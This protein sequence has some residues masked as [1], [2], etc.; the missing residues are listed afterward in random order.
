MNWSCTSSYFRNLIAPYIFRS[1]KLRN[2]ERS[3]R[4]VTA[5]LRTRHASLIRK[6]YFIGTSRKAIE[7]DEEAED[8][9]DKFLGVENSLPR[10]VFAL[11]SNL[12]QFPSLHSLSIGFRYP[13]A[14]NPLEDYD[15]APDYEDGNTLSALWATAWKSLMTTTYQAVQKNKSPRFKELDI[16]RLVWTSVKPFEDPEF[17][18]LLG[19]MERLTLSVRGGQM[20]APWNV[21]TID[22][23][24]NGVAK[25]D[26]LF[27]NHLHSAISLTLQATASGSIGHQRGHRTNLRLAKDQMPHLKEL[28]LEFCCIC[29]ELAGFITSHANTLAKLTLSCCVSSFNKLQHGGRYSWKDLF[30]ALNG[31]KLKALSELVILPLNPPLT[32]KEEIEKAYEPTERN[33]TPEVRQVRHLLEQDPGRRLF[34]YAEL[35]TSYG[36]IFQNFEENVAAF[37]R[38]EDQS[39]YDRVMEQVTRNAQKGKK[40]WNDSQIDDGR[41]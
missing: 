4:A 5:L 16:R 7:K 29:D 2:E 24:M 30:H 38:G 3:G 8:E 17:H 10:I 36:M 18:E 32:L 33:K 6:L 27:Y 11:L 26:A 37:L 1:I 14:N 21:N 19:H 9:E 34:A 20:D 35:D 12:N 15:N 39:A 25:F 13:F 41:A 31:V 28:H 40:G 22:G 23:Y